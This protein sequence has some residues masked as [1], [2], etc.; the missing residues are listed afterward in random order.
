[1]N[2]KEKLNWM[3]EQ[4]IKECKRMLKLIEKQEQKVLEE[5]GLIDG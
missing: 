4:F 5:A 2:N 1:M 3:K